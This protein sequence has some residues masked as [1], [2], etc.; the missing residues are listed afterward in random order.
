MLRF[1]WKLTTGFM[2]GE[3]P[4]R[5]LEHRERSHPPRGPAMLLWPFASRSAYARARK[6][7]AVSTQHDR[8]SESVDLIARNVA[9]VACRIA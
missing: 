2:P 5:R 6:L 1:A 7:D 3:Q 8:M 4:K 9:I